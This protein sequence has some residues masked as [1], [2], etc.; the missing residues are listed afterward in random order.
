MGVMSAKFQVP[1]NTY[2]CREITNGDFK[3]K[4]FTHNPRSGSWYIADSYTKGETTVVTHIVK[5]DKSVIKLGTKETRYVKK[6]QPTAD[7]PEGV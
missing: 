3:G 4:V 1:A 7:L 2:F 5:P 6:A